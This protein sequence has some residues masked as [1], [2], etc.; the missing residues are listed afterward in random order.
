MDGE[1]ICPTISYRH[2]PNIFPATRL[3]EISSWA[4]VFDKK[5]RSPLLLDGTPGLKLHHT[6]GS[7]GKDTTRRNHR[8]LKLALK[9]P[10][11][12]PGGII[13]R[14]TLTAV[15]RT[16]KCRLMSISYSLG[17]TSIFNLPLYNYST[18]ASEMHRV[19]S[20]TSTCIIS[21]RRRSN[22]N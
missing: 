10:D 11:C 21:T 5:M 7:L 15:M 9:F 6:E 13:F 2:E 16:M 8:D 20:W 1:I 17:L 14:L 4:D 3:L 19:W 12:G 22:H 18:S